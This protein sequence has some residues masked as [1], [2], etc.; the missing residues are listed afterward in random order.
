MNKEQAKKRLEEIRES[1]KAEKISYSEIAELQ[2]LKNYI[3]PGDV[4]LLQWSGV[5]EK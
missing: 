5:E 3:E 2:E 4:E 1:I